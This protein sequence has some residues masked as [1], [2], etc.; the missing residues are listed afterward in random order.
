MT[1]VQ[2]KKRFDYIRKKKLKNGG[3]YKN[4]LEVI[5]EDVEVSE[6]PCCRF[7]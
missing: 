2:V 1:E 4:I 7:E 6:L 5:V 3:G